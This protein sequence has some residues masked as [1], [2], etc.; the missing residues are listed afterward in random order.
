MSEEIIS[1]RQEGVG[2]IRLNRPKAL[3][4][5][6]FEMIIAIKK[7]LRDFE[8]DDSIRAILLES[9][10][11][12]G[13]CAGGDIRQTRQYILDD[14]FEKA[15]KFFEEEYSLDCY[16]AKY[17]K[18]IIALTKNII[19]GGGLG[20]AGHARYR[21]AAK[22]AI[23]AMPEAAI[24]FV[25]DCAID[26]LL[27]DIERHIALAFLLSG[28]TVSAF[29]AKE[30]NLSD[31]I[32]DDDDF[33]QLRQSLLGAV[34]SENIDEEIRRIGGQ[35]SVDTNNFDFIKRANICKEAFSGKN[36]IEIMDK[37][38]RQAKSEPV[39]KQ[40]YQILSKH[41]P[42]S[43]S[44]ILISHDRARESKNIDEIVKTDVNLAYFM[45]KRGDFVEGV[46]AV[47][48]DKDKN[49]NWQPKQISEVNEAEIVA[50]VEK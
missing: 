8:K 50:Q 12:R 31:F 5:L 46:R 25:C 19:M 26:Y 11:E 17:Q 48:I 6:S 27:I 7:A 35:F 1:F 3:N 45:A 29:D 13:F 37:L 22:S 20:L 9:A 42:A 32:F 47:I 39:A 10:T 40:F 36:I 41:C 30:L 49:P 18:P 15:Q 16:I 28:Q 34:N 23:F 24:G 44:A 38:Q 43:L 4:A 21:F 2:I 33:A 14:E